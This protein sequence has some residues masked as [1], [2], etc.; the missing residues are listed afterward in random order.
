MAFVNEKTKSRTIDHERG[1][2]LTCKGGARADAIDRQ[3]F[4]LHIGHDV[5]TVSAKLDVKKRGDKTVVRWQVMRTDPPALKGV[6]ESQVHDLLREAL[7][8][9]GLF[10]ERQRADE[11]QVC[12][13]TQQGR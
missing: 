5:I 11:V 3:V 6:S 9:Y 10:Y 7:T 13:N 8:E 4:E 2:V 1:I 12:D